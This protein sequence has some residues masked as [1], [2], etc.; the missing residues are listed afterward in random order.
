MEFASHAM[1]M[2]EERNYFKVQILE[3]VVDQIH[4]Q[5]CNG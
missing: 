3:L 2:K 4:V 1:I 5:F